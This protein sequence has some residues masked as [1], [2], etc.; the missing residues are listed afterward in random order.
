MAYATR[1]EYDV[2][3]PGRIASDATCDAKLEAASM[4]ID[5]ELDNAG[6]DH[7]NPDD[8]LEQ[9]L[10]EVCCSVA[11][12]IMPRDGG[13]PQG[14]T[15]FSVTAGPYSESYDLPTAYSAPMLN[16]YERR[17]LGIGGKLGFARPSYGRLEQS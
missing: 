8:V 1:A 10:V 7:E 15:S 11:D 9:R 2:R 17:L 5:A 12:R 3:F 14:A 16:K 4:A 6:I 13:M